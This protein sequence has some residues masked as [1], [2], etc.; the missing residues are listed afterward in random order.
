LIQKNA[1][2]EVQIERLNTE[3]DKLHSDNVNLEN[4]NK[5]KTLKLHSQIEDLENQNMNF[6]ET[7]NQLNEDLVALNKE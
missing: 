3:I 2:K 4:T 6:E 1:D 7:I 5:Q